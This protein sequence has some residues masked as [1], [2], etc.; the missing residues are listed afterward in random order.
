M[1][2]E[3][4]TPADLGAVIADRRRES[5]K[6]QTELASEVGLSQRYVSQLETGRTTSATLHL[7]RILRRM[8]ATI[9]VSF[10][11]AKPHG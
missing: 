10:D 7:F 9:T 4:R 5:G 1:N 3:V 8:G 6:T 2:Y 11:D